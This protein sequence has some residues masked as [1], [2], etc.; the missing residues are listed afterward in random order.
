MKKATLLLFISTLLTC[1]NAYAHVFDGKRQ[2][3]QFGLGLGAHTSELGYQS[4][5]APS[6]VEAEQRLAISFRVGYGFSNRVVGQFGGKAGSI[7]INDQPAGLAIVGVGGSFYLT[8]LSPSLYL[9]GL[10][11]G[12]TVGL[13]DEE[14]DETDTGDGWLVGIG[15]EIAD[16][17]HL[18][19]S[20]AQAD[21]TDPNNTLNK[22]TLDS[23]FLTLNYI[24]Y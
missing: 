16:R 2:G 7:L 1:A 23:S 9:T 11:G 15:Y 5:F 21:L 3:F 24:W 17:L 14:D 18:E 20:H 19:L 10:V 22:S 13:D 4:N 8:E 6:D 12:A